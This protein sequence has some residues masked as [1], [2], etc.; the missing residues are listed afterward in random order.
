IVNVSAKDL[1]SGKEQ[2]MTITG[3][4]ALSK[5][6]IDRM[7]KEAEAFAAED[8]KRREAAEARNQADQLTYQVETFLKDN[9]DKL[10]DADKAELTSKNDEL[11]QALKDEAA[12]VETL[13]SASE[14]L[15]QTWQKVS[16]QMHEQ[17]AQAQST[18]AGGDAPGTEAPAADADGDED[19]VEG[20]IVD[21]G[22]TS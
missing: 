2:A 14:S 18:A 11:K 3:G 10:S 17:A 16:Q 20:E 7:M 21:E 4:T 8:H 9:G 22:G 15:M 5:D 12:E 6:E 13:R 19:V 1:A